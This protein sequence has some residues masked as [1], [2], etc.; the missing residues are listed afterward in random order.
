MALMVGELQALLSIDDRA[1]NPA[2]RRTENALRS[3]GRQMGDDAER[4]GQEAGTLLGQGL[5]RG[6]DG[7]WR[8]LRGELADAATAAVAEAE[9]VMRRG[10]RQIAAAAGAAGDQAGQQL[11][12]G[13]ADGAEQGVNEAGNRL[14]RLKTMAAGAGVAAGAVLASGMQQALDQN[15]ITA[16]ATAGL[17]ATPAQAQRYGQAAGQLYRNAVV[18][19]FEE[20][21]GAIQAVA[22]SGLLPPDATLG[23]ITTI[24]TKV[25][26]LSTKYNEET[27]RIVRAAQ[28]LL[29]T[30]LAKTSGEAFDLIAQ[31]FTTSAN[32]GED[33]L[34]SINEYSVQFK[35]L[36]IDG[37]TAIGLMS[38]GIA[39]GG[40]DSDQISDAL[41]QFGEKAVAGGK[42]VDEAFKSIGV[43]ADDVRAKLAKGGKS[44]QQALQMTLDALRG[45]KD[46][47]VKLNAATALFGDPGTVMGDALFALDPASAAA[48]SGMDKAGGSVSRLGKQMRSGPAY[49]L[50]KFKQSM[51]QNLVD[52]LG[53]KVVPALSKA[54]GWMQE[55][56]GEIKFGAALI[57]G[58]VVPALVLLGGKAL[59]AGI[60]MARAWVMALG[61]VAWV[62]LAIG[63]LVVLIIAYWDEIKAWTLAAWNWIVDKLKWAKDG[64]L[65]AVAYLGTIPGKISAWFGQAKDWAVEKMTALVGWL[66]G[67]PGR[68]GG[69]LGAMLGVLRQRA[70]S[71]FESFRNAAVQRALALVRWVAGLPGRI[72]R[73]IGSLSSLLTDKGRNV[74]QGLWA[75]ISSMGGWIRSKLI[76][77]A[78]DMIPGP[79]AK[80]LGIASP[81]KVT[82]AQGKW[83]AQGLVAGLTGNQKQ[84]KAA[85]YKLSDIVRDA[86]TGKKERK[87]I[88]RINKDANSLT[89][90][91]GWDA[92][93]ANQLKTAQKRVQDLQKARTDLVNSVRNGI[94]QDADI[95]KQDTGGWGQTAASILAG[96]RQ[97]TAAAQQFAKNLAAL[98]KKG[99]RR[100][101]ISQIAQA[102]VS[103]G[104]S[105]AAALA[106]AS[107]KEIRAINDQ[108]ARL[109]GAAAQAGR[110]A[111]S[112]MYDAGIRA[113][114]GLVRGLTS[115][116]KYIESTMLR[117][118][119]GMSKSIRKA[120]GIKSPSRVMAQVGQYTALG[121]VQGMEGERSAVNSTMASLV[122]TP[123]PG[124]AAFGA[125]GGYGRRGKSTVVVEFRSSGSKWDDMVMEST[126]RTVRKR[127]G[128]DVDLV[129][130]GKRSR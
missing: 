3:S 65:A 71:A 85:A 91:A 4:S 95:T 51:Q 45:T 62:G 33:F 103:G 107:S 35:R 94:M 56:S 108:Q 50:T 39:A 20:G 92:K 79:I 70:T 49:E 38:Q 109:N 112:A 5:I 101:L 125:G 36:G 28:K 82:A 47:T 106:N 75:G 59:W 2:L 41:G 66:R 26:D 8:N 22:K 11:G 37:K 27:G 117:I 24:G 128:G 113:A 16:V 78:K 96:L 19:N 23:Q 99:V 121:L 110:T 17:A 102:G 46:E 119:K 80:A 6:A 42:A 124:G 25:A 120:L 98:Q 83:I 57:T 111:G 77:W 29:A 9:A 31:G 13:I 67:L 15:R 116:Q 14:D 68:I 130:A 89:F 127:G 53:G 129:I 104:A 21:M 64:I 44:G 122:E 87:A 115:H 81:S 88:A 18:T 123:A 54:F 60:Q 118:A 97:D 30:G 105:S 100:D 72:S 7:Q 86:L 1:V 48:A 32:Q 40:R 52:F 61:P 63:G 93:V 126:R 84:V 34:D 55:H 12:D 90:L 73:G 114:Q 74:V 10:G 69:A 43:N 58:L 76:S